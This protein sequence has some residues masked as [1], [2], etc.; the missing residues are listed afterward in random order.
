MIQSNCIIWWR[1]KKKSDCI[2]RV[3]R[4]TQILISSQN[5]FCLPPYYAVE[6]H[7]HLI[8]LSVFSFSQSLNFA[9]FF[10]TF[11]QNEIKIFYTS[12]PKNS[13]QFDVF[14]K[15]RKSDKTWQKTYFSSLK[16]IT[17]S[18]NLSLRPI[19]SC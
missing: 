2:G 14:F 11:L 7:P 4:S 17:F 3:V 9:K 19:F 6:N 16:K 8:I 5:L 15:K 10:S 1:K 18:T 13:I 12:S